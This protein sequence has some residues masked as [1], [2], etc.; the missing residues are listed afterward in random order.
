MQK[1]ECNTYIKREFLYNNVIKSRNTP[2]V[3]YLKII[4]F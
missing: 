1:R 3:A 2:K 4:G